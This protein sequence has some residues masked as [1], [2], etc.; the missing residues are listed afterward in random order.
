MDY[1]IYGLAKLLYNLRGRD[2]KLFI[3]GPAFADFPNPAST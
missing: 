3:K 1:I 2:A